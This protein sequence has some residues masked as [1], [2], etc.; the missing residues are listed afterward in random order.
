MIVSWWPKSNNISY[1]H[2][3][4]FVLI[5]CKRLRGKKNFENPIKKKE[6]Q[7]IS[8]KNLKLRQKIRNEVSCFSS[9]VLIFLGKFL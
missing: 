6:F 1:K 5:L 2:N 3:E 7:K 9:K 8:K 4:D